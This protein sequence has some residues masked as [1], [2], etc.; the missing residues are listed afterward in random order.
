MQ[1]RLRALGATSSTALPAAA[2]AAAAVP[3]PT[4]V[5]M[6]AA[7]DD[8]SDDGS[9]AD[10]SAPRRRRRTDGGG[11]ASS[12]ASSGGGG[13]SAGRLPATASSVAAVLQELRTLWPAQQQQHSLWVV[14]P[15]WLDA[16]LSSG[17]RVEEA[18]HCLAAPRAPSAAADSDGDSGQVQLLLRRRRLQL[19]SMPGLE[20]APDAPLG[21]CGEGLPAA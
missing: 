1:Q 18:G 17:Q 2:A 20:V 5:V 3:V 12:S 15:S 7:G 19:R 9:S 14:V 21:R 13:T 8:G 16:V 6:A 10:G 11:A 4:H